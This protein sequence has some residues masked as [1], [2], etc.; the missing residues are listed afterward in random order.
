MVKHIFRG[1]FHADIGQ[2]PQLDN[3]KRMHFFESS[4]LRIVLIDQ[5]GV[6]ELVCKPV[7]DFLETAKINTES[8]GGQSFA[9]KFQNKTAAIPVD[10]LAVS[11]MSP[12]AVG[13]G[14]VSKY[15]SGYEYTHAGEYT[16]PKQKR[17]LAFNDAIAII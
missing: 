10:E 6:I 12:L 17:I 9:A 14:I 7:F 1:I 4:Q 13:T 3:L 15:F 16:H 5:T 8:F 11:L 2:Y